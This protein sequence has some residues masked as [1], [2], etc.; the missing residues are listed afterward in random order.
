MRQELRGAPQLLQR[1][2][3]IAIVKQRGAGIGV[4]LP[5]VPCVLYRA[6]ID[7]DY[8]RKVGLLPLMQFGEDSIQLSNMRGMIRLLREWR[9]L[10]AARHLH[11]NLQPITIGESQPPR[12]LRE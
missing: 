10:D 3:F 7:G 4:Q 11:G 12:K 6:F 8:L 5:V 9:A 1:I 2:A